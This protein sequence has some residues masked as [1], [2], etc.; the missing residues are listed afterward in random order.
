MENYVFEVIDKTGRKIHLTKERWKHITSPNSLHPYMTNYLEEMKEALTESS[1][2]VLH[3]LDSSKADYY[4][5]IKEKK[6]YLLVGVKYLNGGG[7][8]TTT[9]FTR[10]LIKKA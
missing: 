7:F 9:F 3:I 1:D 8:V 2:I 6:I 5:Y 10:K 4:L